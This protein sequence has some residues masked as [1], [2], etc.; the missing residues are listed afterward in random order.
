MLRGPYGEQ[1]PATALRRHDCAKMFLD[2]D[3]AARVLK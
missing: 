1:C 2:A 3:S